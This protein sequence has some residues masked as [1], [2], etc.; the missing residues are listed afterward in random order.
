MQ[1][2][3]L[4]DK[5]YTSLKKETEDLRRWKDLPC[6]GIGR[7]NMVNTANSNLQIQSNPYQNSNIILNNHEKNNF[8]LNM[9]NQK[10]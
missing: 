10:T 6:S 7:I 3:D 2:K 9:A 5:I 8:Q 4:Y 1:G